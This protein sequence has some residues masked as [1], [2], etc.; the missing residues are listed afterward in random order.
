MQVL[1]IQPYNPEAVEE[2]DKTFILIIQDEWM[3]KMAIRFSSHN[4][5]AIDSTF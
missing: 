3:L 2:K 4:S 1:Y 5:W